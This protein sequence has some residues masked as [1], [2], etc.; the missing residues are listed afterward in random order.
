MDKSNTKSYE[1]LLTRVKYLTAWQNFLG[2]DI[3]LAPHP[4]TCVCVS[5]PVGMRVQIGAV[6]WNLGGRPQQLYL[7]VSSS[8]GIDTKTPP[9][10]LQVSLG[11]CLGW[12]SMH[13]LLAGWLAGVCVMDVC[14][15]VILFLGNGRKGSRQTK[16][17]Q[18]RGIRARDRRALG[19]FMFK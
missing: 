13:L 15:W 19:R 5:I 17:Q 9:G 16:N 3:N 11:V 1:V 14:T 10:S 6:P 8:A 4:P 18:S 7:P 12:L 2:F